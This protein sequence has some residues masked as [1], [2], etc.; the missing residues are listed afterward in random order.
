MLNQ[1]SFSFL[2]KSCP[3]LSK[4]RL[5]VGNVVSNTFFDF[6]FEAKMHIVEPLAVRDVVYRYRKIKLVA[7]VQ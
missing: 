2:L 4:V 3:P 7:R 5:R 1:M 6:G